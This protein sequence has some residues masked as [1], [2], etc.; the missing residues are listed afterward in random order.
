MEGQAQVFSQM[1]TQE[2]H[3]QWEFSSLDNNFGQDDEENCA[4]PTSLFC[5]TWSRFDQDFENP[6]F[7]R[8]QSLLQN[9]DDLDQ[10]QKQTE[11]CIPQRGEDLSCQKAD[12]IEANRNESESVSNSY[13]RVQSYEDQIDIESFFNSKIV[14]EDRNELYL[15]LDEFSEKLLEDS[16]P[17]SSEDQIHDIGKYVTPQI[18]EDIVVA[19]T[20]QEECKEGLVKKITPLKSTHEESSSDDAKSE[21]N[22]CPDGTIKNACKSLGFEKYAASYS[23]SQHQSFYRALEGS[24]ELSTRKGSSDK[25]SNALSVR[26]SCFRALSAFFKNSFSK[27]NRAWQDKRRNK[28]KTKD[29]NNFIDTYIKQEFGDEISKMDPEFY[30][31]LRDAVISILHSHRYKKQEEFTKDIDFSI[32]RDVLYSYTLEARQR[33]MSRPAFALIY[34]HFFVNGAYKFLVSKVQCK[35]KLTAFELEKELV[36]LH[37]DAVTTLQ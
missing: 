17:D 24:V 13:K 7:I 29:M 30:K 31:N 32:I 36:G 25:E 1:I 14:C 9:I 10:T 6:A 26:R 28:K 12:R 18:E 15:R 23:C 33:F 37:H 3:M 8:N 19:S 4:H 21:I 16:H 5:N 11:V 20:T 34:H 22:L 35:S 2:E 27:F